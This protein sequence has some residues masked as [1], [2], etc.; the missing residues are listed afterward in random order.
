MTQPFSIDLRKRVVD[1]V[2]QGNSRRSA[3][4]HF[5][6]S[7]SFVIDLLR[8]LKENG[9]LEPLPCGGTKEGKL[10]PHHDTILRRVKEKPDITLAELASEIESRGT[11]VHPSSI[12]RFL[13][14]KNS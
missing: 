11:K 14:S 12:S 9:S 7:V 5:A 3:A 8:H 4:G 1:F 6:V 2:E 13:C 10:A